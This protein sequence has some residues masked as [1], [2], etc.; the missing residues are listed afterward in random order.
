MKRIK[1]ISLLTICSLFLAA[2][3]TKHSK[4]VNLACELGRADANKFI[5]MYN[6][7]APEQALLT[8]LM[9]V[10]HKETLLKRGGMSD[11]AKYYIETFQETIYTSESSLGQAIFQ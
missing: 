2:C 5:E 10:R 11:E 3:T 6:N 9:D 4:N 1:L 7:K 8:F